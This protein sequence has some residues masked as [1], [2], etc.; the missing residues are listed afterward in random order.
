MQDVLTLKHYKEPLLSVKKKDG[1]GYY[2]A[3]SVSLTTGKL[4]C[5]M[6]GGM[7]DHVGAHA[8]LAHGMRAREYR[9]KYKL[10]PTSALVSEG[11]RMKLKER[12]LE[13]IAK[14]SLKQR[15]EHMEHA[16]KAR[17]REQPRESLEAKNRKGTC[18]DQL[19]AKIK[20]CAEAIGHT[21]TQKEF[22]DFNQSQRFL[23][24]VNKTFGSWKNA[25]KMA[26]LAERP[27]FGGKPR[28]RYTNE[29]L[30]EYLNIFWQEN[31]KVPT[32]TD[33]R[34]GLLPDSNVYK[35]RFGSVPKARTLAGIHEHPKRWD[36][37]P[38]KFRDPALNGIKWKPV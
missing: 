7:F 1:Y 32:E 5:H 9:E 38:T 28:Q 33:F 13:F 25:I 2:G 16:R 12:T 27:Q 37:L 20:E 24:L 18:P 17:R 6:C 21:P 35:R 23:H 22:I 31:Q 10:S 14:M 30:L 29:E 3:L 34:R 36:T 8:W 15:K 19:L 4:Q 26:K 11:L